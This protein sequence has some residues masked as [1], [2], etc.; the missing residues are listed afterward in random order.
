MEFDNFETG[1]NDIDRRLD[2]IIRKILPDLPLSQIYKLIRKNLIRINDKK[3]SQ[4]YKIQEKDIINIASFIL[5]E[6]K[7]NTAVSTNNIQNSSNT[8]SGSL[9]LDIIFKN[10]HILIINKPYDISVQGSDNTLDKIVQSEY[11]NNLSI[12]DKSLSFTPGPLHRL[13]RKTTGILCFSQSIQGARWFTEN[14]KN[15]TIQKKYAGIIQGN[16]K[17]AEKWEDFISKTEN[18]NSFF[19]TVTAKE[20]PAESE[21]LEKKALTFVTPIAYGNYKNYPV[22]LALFDIKTGRTHQIRSQSALHNHPLIGDTAYGGIELRNEGRD[23]FLHAIKL[24]FPEGNP[25]ELPEEITAPLTESFI[26][27]V[28]TC[29]FKDFE[30]Y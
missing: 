10:Q 21:S 2:K 16:L 12:N 4:E 20:I 9:K 19:H 29:G 7:K 26:S 28:K 14:I 15:H 22:T 8:I 11:R 1:I 3:T 27:F 23:F 5:S 30:L 18:K 24:S 17:T 6:N 25:L 13:D